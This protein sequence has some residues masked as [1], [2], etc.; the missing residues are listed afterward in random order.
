MVES[1]DKDIVRVQGWGVVPLDYVRVVVEDKKT[2]N[3]S[4]PGDLF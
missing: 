1:L 4:T 3:P 2:A